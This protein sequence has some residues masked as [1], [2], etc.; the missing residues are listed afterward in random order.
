MFVFV[1]CSVCKMKSKLLSEVNTVVGGM[2]HGIS[3]A[4]HSY[5]INT[6]GSGVLVRTSVVNTVLPP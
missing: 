2:E 3:S 4:V 6:G 1:E 5:I